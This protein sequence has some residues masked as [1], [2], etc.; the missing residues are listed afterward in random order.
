[1]K[2]PHNNF[3]LIRTLLAVLVVFGHFK[4][5][6]GGA[7][8]GIFGYADFAVDAFF[9]ISGYLVYGSFDKQQCV[10]SFYIRRFFRIYPLYAVVIILQGLVMAY[11]AGSG[12]APAHELPR[13]LGLNL[14]F[15]NFAAPGFGTLLQPLLNPGINPSLWTLKIEVAFYL[16]LPLLWYFTKRFGI[17]F[18]LLIYI[19]SSVYVA[20]ALHY[21]AYTVAKQ[22]PG[23]IRF[24]AIGMGLYCCCNAIKIPLV[25]AI[26]SAL[27]LFAF[28]SMRFHIYLALFILVYPLCGGL[29]VYICALRLPALPLKYDISYG[30]YLIHGPLIQFS[31]L[32]HW[33]SN[34]PR[35]FCM[36]LATVMT[37][38]F[39]ASQ[40]IEKPMI[41]LGHWLSE[42][43]AKRR[44]TATGT[45]YV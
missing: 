11:L 5:L 7:A 22:L 6:S 28:C 20:M 17:T 14:V 12:A 9:V 43:W 27:L 30:I 36:L 8:L 32:L 19:A 18:L 37:L 39:V 35:F 24:F 16:L 23:K 44:K 2:A 3:T 21:D 42:R 1:M 10:G 40:S 38:A 4:I 34:T 45:P 15:A 26:I 29:L 25:Y 33:F 41:D 31:L 13:Y